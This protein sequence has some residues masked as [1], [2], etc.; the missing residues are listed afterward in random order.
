MIF[1]YMTF[2]IN[3]FLLFIKNPLSLALLIITQ[4]LFFC[5]I[6]NF[7]LNLYW[8]SYILYLI[9]LGGMLI[10]F[11]YMCSISS[12]EIMKLNIK[13]FFPITLISLIYFYFWLSNKSY[14]ILKSPN[15]FLNNEN[16][17]SINKI[18]NNFTLLISFMLMFYLL[19]TLF[20]VTSL[21]YYNFGPLR[22][23]N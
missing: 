8:I 1:F 14:Q 11:L 10:L 6:M 7:N 22:S 13:I 16:L 19:I 5:L 15:F 21:S 4:T 9:M 18:Y 2:L 12:N 3:S 20:M 17:L 23:S